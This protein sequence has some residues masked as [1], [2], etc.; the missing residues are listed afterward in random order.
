[1]VYNLLSGKLPFETKESKR[2]PYSEEPLKEAASAQAVEFLRSVLHRE[3]YK[4]ASART[5]LE[6]AWFQAGNLSLRASEGT[7]GQAALGS[8]LPEPRTSIS[9]GNFELLEKLIFQH[10]NLTA[11]IM[12]PE[13]A[14]DEETAFCKDENCVDTID[15]QTGQRWE[16]TQDKEPSPFQTLEEPHSQS[17]HLV[18]AIRNTDLESQP[19][20]EKQAKLDE[21]RRQIKQ[22]LSPI[23]RQALSKDLVRASKAGDYDKALSLFEMGA[24]VNLGCIESRTSLHW[25]AERKDSRLVAFLL[26]QGADVSR[27]DKN[28]ETALH[29]AADRE[30]TG[31]SVVDLLLAWDSDIEARNVYGYTPLHCTVRRGNMELSNLFMTKGANIRT[32][33]TEGAGLLHAVALAGVHELLQILLQKGL[34]VNAPN[35]FLQRPLHHAAE[36]GKTETVNILLAAGSKVNSV[37]Q[38]GN[39]PLLLASRNGHT[40]IVTNLLENGADVQRKNKK[41]MTAL[42]VAA[43]KG[44][45]TIIEKLIDRKADI[46]VRDRWNCPPLDRAANGGHDE[47]CQI[48][49]NS[50]AKTTKKSDE[51]T[52]YTSLH[53]AAALGSLR[54]F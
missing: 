51:V 7:P 30:Y 32:I 41:E 52:G 27:V 48:L 24:D 20:E 12:K 40:D 6:H 19:I 17:N 46:N 36:R 23:R 25:A 1:M 22:E 35:R 54:E 47:I 15:I 4:R 3:P 14:R 16:G 21:T 29:F 2:R 39:T 5:S 13:S 44:Y 43:E 53:A 9:C 34:D 26:E 18:E 37:E 28:W 45:L 50:G 8:L 33:G 38:N 10:Q 11:L 49:I 42:H 31:S